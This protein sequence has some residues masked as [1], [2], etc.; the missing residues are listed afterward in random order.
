[1]IV[2]LVVS[3]TFITIKEN[4]NFVFSQFL[5]FFNP[6]NAKD[7]VFRPVHLTY[8]WSRIMKRIARADLDMKIP[9]C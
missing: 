8:L 5:Y 3:I 2:R 9:V 6:L 7:G 4:Q 1:M